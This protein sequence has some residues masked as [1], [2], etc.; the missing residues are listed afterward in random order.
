MGA[1]LVFVG[2]IGTMLRNLRR[3]M[4]LAAERQNRPRNPWEMG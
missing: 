1:G 3:E 4:R 2:I